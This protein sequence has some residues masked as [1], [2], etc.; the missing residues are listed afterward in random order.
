MMEYQSEPV[1]VAI[2]LTTRI[3]LLFPGEGTGEVRNS[4]SEFSGSAHHK[5]KEPPCGEVMLQNQK[6]AV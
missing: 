2:S 4:F 6:R 5:L 1:K 3:L